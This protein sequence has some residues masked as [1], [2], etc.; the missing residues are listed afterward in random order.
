MT[1]T[2]K[3]YD[4]SWS[5]GPWKTR[6]DGDT[7][8]N[9]DGQIRRWNTTIQDWEDADTPAP[10]RADD[11]PWYR[12]PTAD[13]P[14]QVRPEDYPGDGWEWSWIGADEWYQEQP[15]LA[16]VLEARRIEP[17]PVTVPVEI[18]LLG[19]L[20]Q[21]SDILDNHYAPDQNAVC[22]SE[23]SELCALIAEAQR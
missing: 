11:P 18:G 2:P 13:M 1:T 12:E 6:V 5:A 9:E 21:D 23:R 7:Y 14:G 3:H 8:T 10:L 4:D 22:V 20:V 19:R 16:F 17:E 15:G